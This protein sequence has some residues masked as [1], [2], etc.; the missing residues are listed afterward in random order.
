MLEATVRGE[1]PGPLKPLSSPFAGALEAAVRREHEAVSRALARQ[2]AGEFPLRLAV[3]GYGSGYLDAEARAE[4]VA[5]LT[6]APLV[7]VRPDGSYRTDGMWVWPE[8]IAEFVLATGIP[9]EDEFF[10]HIEDRAFCF[11]AE[12]EPGVL[13]RARLLL[14]EPSP[15]AEGGE[16]VREP[17]VPGRP[18]SPAAGERLGELADWHSEWQGRHAGST[19]FRGGDHPDDEDYDRHHVD[20]EASAEAE[21][22]YTTKARE[23]MGLDPETGRR[24]D[25]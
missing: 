15:P 23:I 21:A 11:P 2:R 16:R 12:L 9:P 10:L 13:D 14:M 5:F 4:M 20:V 17:S 8:S 7:V 1:L 19:P 3:P 25:L 18:P 6:G 22:E 24:V